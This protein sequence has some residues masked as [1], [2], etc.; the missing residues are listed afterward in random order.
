M[1]DRSQHRAAH[2]FRYQDNGIVFTNTSGIKG[3]SWDFDCH[4]NRSMYGTGINLNGVF[5]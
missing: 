2:L 4:C 5:L 3:M 1:K